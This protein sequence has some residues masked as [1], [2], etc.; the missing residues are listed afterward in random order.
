VGISSTGHPA[1][2]RYDPETKRHMFCD[3]KSIWADH[4]RQTSFTTAL[5]GHFDLNVYMISLSAQTMNDSKLE[6]LFDIL[7]HRCIVLLEDIDSAGIHRESMK[8]PPPPPPP[9]FDEVPA[10]PYYNF[11]PFGTRLPGEGFC[12][13]LSGLLNVLDGVR[14]AE[15]RIVIMT[16][17][18]PESLDEALIRRG[19]IDQKVHFGC[20]S[21]ETAVKLFT[22]IYLKADDE[23]LD[24]ETLPEAASIDELARQ[25]GEKLEENAFTPAEVQGYLIDHRA[26]AERAVRE[27]AEF[28]KELSTTKAQGLN[29]PVPGSG[30]DRVVD[31]EEIKIPGLESVISGVLDSGAGTTDTSSETAKLK[32]MT[33]GV[34][35]HELDFEGPAS[36]HKNGYIEP[37]DAYAGSDRS[38]ARDPLSEIVDQK[39]RH[40]SLSP[41]IW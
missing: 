11:D 36:S 23:L 21:R 14:A 18:T 10:Q 30:I 15:G 33:N 34:K 1:Q 27:A 6:V 9:V 38:R 29:V 20:A 8:P 16:S 31:I 24:G 19:R 5:A 32:P 4:G 2:A 7:P 35:P 41:S 25:F 12:I 22:Q 26:D 40:D 3:T 39:G 28:F 37:I 17:N 13:T